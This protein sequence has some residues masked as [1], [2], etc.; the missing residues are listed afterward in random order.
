MNITSEAWQ[1]AGPWA[2]EDHL[3]PIRTGFF[4]HPQIKKKI[5]DFDIKEAH[6]FFF[7]FSLSDADENAFR[8]GFCA[9]QKLSIQPDNRIKR[10]IKCSLIFRD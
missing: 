4:S 3:T 7:L 8:G 5:F 6:D 10:R 1:I 2:I 9:Q